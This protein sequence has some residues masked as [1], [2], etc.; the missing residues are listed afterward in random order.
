M[1]F[2]LF[3]DPSLDG[4]W[5]LLGITFLVIFDIPFRCGCPW[6]GLWGVVILGIT[7]RPTTV[8]MVHTAGG[9]TAFTTESTSE[10]EKREILVSKYIHI[11][12]I[13]NKSVDTYL[14]Q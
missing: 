12:T 7:F 8:G 14:H 5:D 1:S 9:D 11:G 4:E 6:A 2:N 10:K 13:S 3:E